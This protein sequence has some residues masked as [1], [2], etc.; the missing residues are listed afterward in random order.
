[1]QDVLEE[2]V[3]RA[4]LRRRAEEIASPS[5]LLPRGAVP[6]LDRIGRIGEDHIE[7]A[8]L[9]SLNKGRRGKRVAARDVEVCYAMDDEVHSGNGGGDCDEFLPEESRGACLSPA[10]LHLREARDEHAARAAGRVVDVLTRLRFEHLRHKVHE[11]SVGVEL[12]CGVAA[13]IG[14]FLDE[15]LVTV[16]ELVFRHRLKGEVVLREVFD[17][18]LERGVGELALVCPRGIAEHALQTLR[19]GGLDGEKCGEQ[20][21]ADIARD[22]SHVAP[23]R[24]CGND[25]SVICRIGG[26]PF[27]AG[28]V[29]RLS[30]VLV[31][32]VGE[33]FEEHQREDVLLVVASIDK[34]TQERGGAPEIA[35]ELALG[36][37]LAHC[38][39]PPWVRTILR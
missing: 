34:A 16:P 20:R 1:M 29:E 2:G 31:P 4:P 18:V 23:V 7:D 25:E 28:F 37:L 33:A 35:L 39:Q 13:V 36:E 19:V 6:L 5:V 26:V 9:V 15:V 32:N 3:I 24:P 14:E 21:L 17:E 8:Q 10:P 11:G 22:R 38:S 27:V 12:L 30:V